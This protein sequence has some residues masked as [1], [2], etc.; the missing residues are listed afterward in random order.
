MHVECLIEMDATYQQGTNK[1]VVAT[2][3][4]VCPMSHGI[5]QSASVFNVSVK[6]YPG[7]EGTS[8]CPMPCG[9]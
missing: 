3:E 4:G 2:V 6:I 7:L 5:Y 1:D 8:I 9:I